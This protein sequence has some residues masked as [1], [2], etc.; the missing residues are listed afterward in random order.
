MNS[1]YFTGENPICSL[2]IHPFI[3]SAAAVAFFKVK[4]LPIQQYL[5]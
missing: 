3:I 2:N 1:S 5:E 4:L